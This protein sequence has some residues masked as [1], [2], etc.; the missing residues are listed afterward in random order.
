MEESNPELESFRQQWKAEVIAKSTASGSREPTPTTA[1]SGP[2]SRPPAAP[3]IA[4]NRAGE[5]HGHFAQYYHD[6]DGVGDTAE[7]RN[8]ESS[9]DVEIQPQSALEHYEL[10]VEKESQG[11]LGESLNLYRKAL[12]VGLLYTCP[13]HA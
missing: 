6:L 8:G 2:S 13:G 4:G 1:A 5:D 10:A 12:R 11:N 3:R 9:K 7:P